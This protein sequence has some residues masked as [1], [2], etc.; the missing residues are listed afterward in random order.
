[1]QLLLAVLSDS[2]II[3]SRN[4]TVIYIL[5]FRMFLFGQILE[6]AGWPALEWRWL[7]LGVVLL[8]LFSAMM[9]G[10]F[11]MIAAVCADFL[12]KPRAQAMKTPS[13]TAIWMS[14]KAFFP[15]ISQ[16]LLP[17][18]VGYGLYIV[19][20]L[21]LMLPAFPFLSQSL[22]ILEKL[23]PLAPDARINFLLSL[24]P[25][26]QNDIMTFSLVIMAGLLV[27]TL[28]SILVMFW[29]AFVVFYRRNTLQAFLGSITHCFRNPLRVLA[30]LGALLI[31][32]MPLILLASTINGGGSGFSLAY[33][34]IQMLNLVVEL[35]STIV[36]FVYIYRTVGPPLPEADQK[37]EDDR[38]EGSPTG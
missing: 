24:P 18:T 10:W 27:Y 4:F 20:L 22:P 2:L 8:M 35:Y 5:L 15:G 23:L 9:G 37:P 29:P 31:L 3:G 33:V 25:E 17:F 11:N 28:F 7:L 38:L 1:M 26:R 34:A 16:F 14:F 21:L 30:L 6:Q 36:I 12:G 13:P 32:R 19:L